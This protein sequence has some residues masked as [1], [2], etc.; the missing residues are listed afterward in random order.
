VKTQAQRLENAISKVIAAQTILLDVALEFYQQGD[1][2]KAEAINQAIDQLERTVMAE[3]A[4]AGL[5][6]LCAKVRGS[7]K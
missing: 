4:E 5:I 1:R 6:P 7:E 2:E 3:S